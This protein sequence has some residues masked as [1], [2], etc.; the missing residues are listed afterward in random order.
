ML[1]LRSGFRCNK[2]EYAFLGYKKIYG[3]K[4]AS[5]ETNRK[6]S[7]NINLERGCNED[8]YVEVNWS[9]DILIRFPQRQEK[10]KFQLKKRRNILVEIQV[11][12]LCSY[13]FHYLNTIKYNQ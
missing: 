11:E 4:S 12:D 9:F 5:C 3:L 6:L 7:S 2:G 13:V 1:L 10:G 8:S